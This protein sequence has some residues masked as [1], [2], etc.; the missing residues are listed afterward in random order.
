MIRYHIC[1]GPDENDRKEPEKNAITSNSNWTPD[2]FILIFCELNAISVALYL[3][4]PWLRINWDLSNIRF[5]ITSNSIVIVCYGIASE[6]FCPRPLSSNSYFLQFLGFALL[7]QSFK[8]VGWFTCWMVDPQNNN[9]T[10]QCQGYL[11]HSDGVVDTKNW[12]RI[13]LFWEHISH[14]KEIN[15]DW[16]H[17]GGAKT[18]PFTIFRRNSETG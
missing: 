5:C 15:T 12:Q 2:F 3:C 16:K 13:R 9:R 10:N 4:L 7:M 6:E 11:K 1:S 18:N 17:D 8:T 14:D